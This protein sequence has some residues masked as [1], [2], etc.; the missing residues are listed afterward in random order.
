MLQ[1]EVIETAASEEDVKD[2]FNSFY[3]EKVDFEEPE[4]K[5]VTNPDGIEEV[6]TST[7]SG[8]KGISV[9][10]E[11]ELP[12]Q[13][14]SLEMKQD[15]TMNMKTTR[16]IAVPDTGKT[17]GKGRQLIELSQIDPGRDLFAIKYM[18]KDSSEAARDVKFSTKI[19]SWEPTNL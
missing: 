4:V 7:K 2:F 12:P 11:E 13:K 3:K 9:K 19:I 6:A 17:E 10:E 8:F 14:M 15:G 1:P 18:S 16:P 5:T